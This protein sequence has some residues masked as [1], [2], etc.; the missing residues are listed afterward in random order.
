MRPC[1]SPR[2]RPTA[3]PQS[4]LLQKRLRSGTSGFSSTTV[5]GSGL[6]TSGTCTSPAPSRPRE[7]LFAEDPARTETDRV[8]TR[9]DS[10]R[11]SLPE[12]ERR[13]DWERAEVRAEAREDDPERAE[14]EERLPRAALVRPVGVAPSSPPDATTGASPQVSQYNSPPPMSS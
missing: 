3:A 1:R 6:A 7:E 10:E 9:P 2:E 11:E 12:T 13:E 14:P 5:A 4:L 8:E